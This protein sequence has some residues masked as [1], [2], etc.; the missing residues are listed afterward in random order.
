MSQHTYK[1]GD[2]VRAFVP[3]WR[4]ARVY[5]VMSVRE[6]GTPSVM[7]AREDGAPILRHG[8]TPSGLTPATEA[9]WR[10][11]QSEDRTERKRRALADAVTDAPGPEYDDARDEACEAWLTF[12]GYTVTAPA[13]TPTAGGES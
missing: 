10:A 2:Y 13:A 5:R 7:S 4:S 12:R 9:E 6:D 11:Q 1:A 3:G 8:Y